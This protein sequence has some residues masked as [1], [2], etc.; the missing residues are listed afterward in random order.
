M[1]QR[2]TKERVDGTEK[3]IMGLKEMILEMKKS[4]DRMADEMRENHSYKRREESETSD[5]SVRK[6]KGE[7]EDATME[8]NMTNVD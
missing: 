3:E 1:A 4:M 6:L 5:G 2:Q 7:L 8:A